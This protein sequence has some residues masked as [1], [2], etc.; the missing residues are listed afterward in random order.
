MTK[1]RTKTKKVKKKRTK[2]ETVFPVIAI[3]FLLLWGV[4]LTTM[5]TPNHVSPNI[6]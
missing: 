5:K 4:I 1:M 3:D 6:P 2:M